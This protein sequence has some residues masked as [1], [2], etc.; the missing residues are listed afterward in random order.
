MKSYQHL[1]QRFLSAN[2]GKQHFACHSHH[3]WPDVTRQAMLQYWD[4]SASLADDK[5]DVIFGKK[6]PAVQQ[7]I[8]GILNTQQPGQLVFAPNTH[9]L[10]YRILSC[11]DWSRPLRILTTDSEFHSF[12]RQIDRLAELDNL[13]VEKVPTLPFADFEQRFAE[14]AAARDW[15]LIF[16]SQVFFNSGLA[17][18]D[19]GA[20]VEAAPPQAIFVIDGYHGFMALPTDLSSVAGRAFYLAGSYKYAQGG[21]GC[22]FAHVPANC[23]LRPLYTGWFAEFGELDQAKDGRVSYST[24]GMRFAGATMD[25]SALYRLLAVLELFAQQGLTVEKVH[26][27][28]QRCQQHFLGML[29]KLDHSLLNRAALVQHDADYHGHFLTFRLQSPE[30]VQALHRH[31]KSHG[32]M[33][34]ARG[35]RLRFG[36]ALYH[37]PGQYD[38]HCLEGL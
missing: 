10:L 26:Q 25:Y 32:V 6:V 16:V 19:L 36:F 7:H 11:L 12:N 8:A 2:A 13:V 9:E 15:D 14:T 35:D 4:D 21:E 27:H 33:T 29:D 38:L 30:Q 1:Y 24:D 37:D 17:V 22:C 18:R 20:L 3:Y 5:W 31:L 23:D 34:D 28:V